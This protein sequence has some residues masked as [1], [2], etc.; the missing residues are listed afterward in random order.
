METII[1][2]WGKECIFADRPRYI[3]KFLHI[4]AGHRLSL[5]YHMYK[6]ETINLLSGKVDLTFVDEK[7]TLNYHLEPGHTFLI[8]PGQKHRLTALEDSVIIEVS[9]PGMDDVVRLS[10]DYGRGIDSGD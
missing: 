7:T 10:D 6:E 3:A 2:P 4:K 8:E 1:K 5:Q 9:T